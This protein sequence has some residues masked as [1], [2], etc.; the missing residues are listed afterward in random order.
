MDRM[1]MEIKTFL[2]LIVMQVNQ[3][4]E[5]FLMN[6]VIVIL[7][8][9]KLKPRKEEGIFDIDFFYFFIVIYF[10]NYPSI[11]EIKNYQY[12]IKIIKN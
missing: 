8:I 6:Y 1:K 12:L 9:L 5:N 3:F 2:N 10:R 7:N 4:M 11:Y